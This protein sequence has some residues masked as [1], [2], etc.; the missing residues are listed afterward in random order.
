MKDEGGAQRDP[1]KRG[2]AKPQSD[3]AHAAPAMRPAAR[4]SSRLLYW[5]ALLIVA[6]F[7]ASP[8]VRNF[9]GGSGNSVPRG[10]AYDIDQSLQF[11]REGKYRE[12]VGAAQE[13]LKL[14]PNSAIAYNNLSVAYL[15]LQQFDK[16]LESSQAALRIDPN[17]ELAKNNLAW[18][19]RERQ[20]SEA[21]IAQPKTAEDWVNRSLAQYQ[22]GGFEEC[23]ASARQ[24]VTLKPELPEAHNNVAACALALRRWDDAIDA[25][26]IAVRLN[27][28]SQLARNNLAAAIQG[29][30]AE[31]AGQGR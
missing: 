23:L 12:A 10:A 1:S 28:G 14:E 17:F 4:L 27:P 31:A 5:L 9:F 24:A 13:A 29:K 19:Q 11:Y 30:Q 7:I 6:A 26:R 21:A 3:E 15:Q 8:H 25:G 22:S 2:A 20:K 18:I 16:A